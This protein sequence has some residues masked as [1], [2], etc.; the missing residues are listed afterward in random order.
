MENFLLDGV[1]LVETIK[2]K[3][4]LGIVIV[5]FI[6]CLVVGIVF[7]EESF[8]N[9]FP[10]FTI[11]SL[12]C[13]LI[14]FMCCISFFVPSSYIQED[15]YI[16]VLEEN[17][18]LVEFYKRYEIEEIQGDYFTIKIREEFDNE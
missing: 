17:V 16:V 4:E 10:F 13:F 3:N 8:V 15:K 9:F 5:S 12:L 14:S 1:T 11:V 7:L 18:D 2:G 6:V